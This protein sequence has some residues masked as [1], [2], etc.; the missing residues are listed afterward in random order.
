MDNILHER[1]LELNP[2][3]TFTL[4]QAAGTTASGTVEVALPYDAFDLRASPPYQTI[5]ETS[6]YFPFRRGSNDT[7]WTLG[8]TFLQEAYLIVDWERSSSTYIHAIGLASQPI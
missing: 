3:V 7:Q 6:K 5:N 4:R 2:S 1:L 8:R